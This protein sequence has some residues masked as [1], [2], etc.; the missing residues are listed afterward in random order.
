MKNATF[1]L[2]AVALSTL[3][4]TQALAGF[5]NNLPN[6]TGTCVVDVV[7][8]DGV[9]SVNQ[10][11]LNRHLYGNI[12]I[13]DLYVEN[14]APQKNIAIAETKVYGR[15]EVATYSSNWWNS[16]AAASWRFT[17]NDN[18]DNIWA[19]LK[20]AYPGETYRIDV[21]MN[22]QVHSAYVRVDACR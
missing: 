13:L 16:N 11:W 15:N 3:S 14:L 1:A 17:T 4:A 19:L 21:T 2:S 5:E 20:G 10:G 22:G 8:D 7:S 12:M 6:N 9:I 18:R